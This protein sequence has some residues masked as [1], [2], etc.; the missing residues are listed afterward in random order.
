[1]AKEYNPYI[2]IGPGE[3]IK[4]ELDIRNWKQGDLAEILGISLKSVNKLMKNKQAI[5]IE[6]AKLLSKAFGQSPQYWANL[7]TNYRLRLKDDTTR[8]K[9]VGTKAEIYKY[10]P[11]KE[12][13]K[14]GWIEP[15]ED[16]NELVNEIKSFWNIGVL[17]FSFLDEISLPNLR[18]SEAFLQYN[19]YYA[20]TWF[21][22]AQ[23]CAKFYQANKYVEVDLKELAPLIHRYSYKQNGVTSFLRGLNRA[24]VKF[25]I[26]SHL[27][28]TYI[29]GATFYDEDNPVIVYTRR[30]DRIDNFWFTIAHEIAHI[31]LHMKKKDDFF[32]DSLE[33]L[34]TKTEKEADGFTANLLRA[35]EILKYFEPF[36]KYIS[37]ARVEGCAHTLEIRPA[38][39]VGVLQHYG[40]LDRKNL[41]RF[42]NSVSQF[43]PKGYLAEEYIEKARKLF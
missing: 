22:M 24:G 37:I 6:T 5:T 3:F 18:K 25:F 23:R 34:T 28:K 4:E 30:Y 2:N 29:D 42:K 33:E 20:L 32:I 10:M 1:M 39:I 19:K 13:V 31:L 41:N 26:L 21:R 9:T 43:I 16:I 14:K 38:I 8:E 12:M 17:N 11:I 36:R 40:M 7:D 15:R 35:G 27:Q